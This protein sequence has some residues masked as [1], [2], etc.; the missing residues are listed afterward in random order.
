MTTWNAADKSAGTTLSGGDLI[1]TMAAV[2]DGVRSTT[3]KSSGKV[4]FS[5]TGDF[6]SGNPVAA[7]SQSGAD[8]GGNDANSWGVAYVSAA[9][10]WLLINSGGAVQ[11]D[12][13][14]AAPTS[15]STVLVL[16]DSAGKLYAQCDGNNLF[17]GDPAAGTGGQTIATATW[18]AAA[19]NLEISGVAV[20][21]ANF[22]PGSLPSGFSDWDAGGGSPYTLTAAQGTF[23]TTGQAANLNLGPSWTFVGKTEAAVSASGNYTLTEPSGAQQND[24]LVVDFATRSNVIYTNTDWTFP[25]SGT[26][27]NTTNNTTGS[28]VS[29]QTGYCIRGSSA[30]SYVFNRTGGSRCLG[31]VRAYRSS[32]AGTPSFD[33]SA[34]VAMG[35]ASG[36][37]T[38]TGGVT[39]TGIDELIVTG[40]YGARANTVSAMDGV[41]EVTGN[42]G[43]TDTTTAPT[44]GTW[45]ERSDRNNGTSPTVALACYD[46]VKRTA[47]STGNLTATESQSARHGMTAMAFKHPAASGSPYTLTA[48]KGTFTVT[49][50]SAGLKRGLKTA[51]AAGSYAITG[52]T[53]GLKAGKKVGAAVG[54]FNITG[55]A[56]GF[57]RT[58]AVIANQG[59]FSLFGQAAGLSVGK[60]ITA[61]AGAFALTG[62]TANFKRT[63]AVAA[64]TGTFAI[65]GQTAGLRAGLGVTAFG[66]S[67]AI[68]GQNAGSRRTYAL[69]VDAGSVSINGQ[70]AGLKTGKAVTAGTGSVAITGQTANLIYTPAG[71][72]LVLT[73]DAGSVVVTG[74]DADLDKG[75]KVT[76]S[77]GAVAISGQN[78]I[79]RVGKSVGATSGSYVIT[80]QDAT[81]R[82]TTNVG[83]EPG[84]YNITGQSAILSAGRQV[85]ASQGS[86]HVTGQ[87]ASFSIGG[88]GVY[89]LTAEAAAYLI[90]GS[91]AVL[92][93]GLKVGG[94][95]LIKPHWSQVKEIKSHL[96]KLPPRQY[97]QVHP[98]TLKEAAAHLAAA[99]GNARA[100]SLTSTQRVKI[101]TTAAKARWK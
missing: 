56:A 28:I 3:S 41:T 81:L 37:V 9:G 31:T 64:N 62:Q 16:L 82:R 78:V 71:A 79:L 85:G 38:L 19:S 13:V 42:S 93:A 59:T 22:T 30:P 99:G 72:D 61:A 76:A 91:D 96:P 6:L 53:V 29:Y 101:A 10:G 63:Y 46:A 23:A 18:F 68:T 4:A 69:A 17:G 33:T 48:D 88:T 60:K 2:G 35:A 57:R 74:Q 80:G 50:V 45:I 5:V 65:T 12:G 51:G 84:A 55:Q 32:R 97:V 47:G 36:T 14:S 44:L 77:A 20:G 95:T 89:S 100:A 25:Q 52:Q 7:I 39:T 90:S 15:S 40:V 8:Y 75:S 70:T 67:F 58:L 86:Y 83:F 43:A 21:T 1:A 54:T 24:I 27:G 11:T 73:A 87:D 66:T 94:I 98:I 92:Q 26:T 49:G 34:E